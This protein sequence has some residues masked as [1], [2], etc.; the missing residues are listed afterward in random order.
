M[1]PQFI[2]FV[3]TAAGEVINAF[4]WCRDALSGIARAEKDSKLFGV[5]ALNIWAEPVNSSN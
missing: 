4:T 1:R 5:E 3:E 2:I